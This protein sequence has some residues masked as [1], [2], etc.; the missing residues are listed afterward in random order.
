METQLELKAEL[1]TIIRILEAK[2]PA[3][4]SSPENQKLENALKSDMAEYFSALD[5]TL[6]INEIEMLYY[7]YVE[8]E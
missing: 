2:L 5:E 6:P 3:N 1:D 4:I 7:K 8:R